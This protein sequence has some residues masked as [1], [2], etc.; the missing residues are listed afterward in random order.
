M[1]MCYRCCWPNRSTNCWK[2]HSNCYSPVKNQLADLPFDAVSTG[3]ANESSAKTKQRKQQKSQK[4]SQ[5]TPL[6]K[7]PNQVYEAELFRLQTELVKLQEWVRFSGARIV[8]IFEGRDGAGKGG[9]IKRI[10]NIS[11]RVSQGS[12]RCPRRPIGSAGSGTT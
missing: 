3:S 10:P 12:P 7:I 1:S 9:T 5:K 2:P 4:T 6:P 11:T 8:V